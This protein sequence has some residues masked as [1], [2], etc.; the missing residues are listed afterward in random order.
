MFFNTAIKKFYECIVPSET[1]YLDCQSSNVIYLIECDSCFLQYVGEVAQK[2]SARF[3]GDRA[4]FKHPE[5]MGFT[6]FYP[7]ISIKEIVKTHLSKFR[8]WNK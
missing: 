7:N 2:L 1:T 5:N 4:G 8:I 6:E 3:N